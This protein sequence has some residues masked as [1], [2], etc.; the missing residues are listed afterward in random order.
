MNVTALVIVPLIDVLEEMGIVDDK[1]ED[2]FSTICDYIGNEAD[3]VPEETEGFI[4]YCTDEEL[5]GD[6]LKEAKIKVKDFNAVI[7]KISKEN[8]ELPVFV[9]F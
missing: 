2:A 6:A 8:N 4:T 9:S 1:N 7:E 3:G 5:L